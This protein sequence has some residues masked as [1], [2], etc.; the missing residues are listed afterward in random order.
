MTDWTR[1]YLTF[2]S[3][4]EKEAD[5]VFQEDGGEAARD[6]CLR[7]RMACK[8]Y[9]LAKGRQLPEGLEFTDPDAPKPKAKAKR[10]VAK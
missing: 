5:D 8:K 2:E 7:I 3:A 6:L 9:W 4:I 10:R 1:K